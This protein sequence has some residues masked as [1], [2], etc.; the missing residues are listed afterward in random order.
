MGL[1]DPDRRFTNGS[2]ELPAHARGVL[3]LPDEQRIP[4]GNSG[5]VAAANGGRTRFSERL[6][7]KNPAQPED[8]WTW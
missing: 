4:A 2:Y 6:R 3:K 7:L 1:R 5:M 8:G